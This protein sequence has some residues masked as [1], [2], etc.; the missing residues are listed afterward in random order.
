[1]LAVRHE[2]TSAALVRHEIAAD[3][4]RCAIGQT[5]IDEVVLVASELV[6]NAIR[7]TDASQAPLQISWDVDGDGVMVRV[8]DPSDTLPTPLRA[9]PRACSGRGLAI[10]EAMS[11]RWG[12]DPAA[13]GK[14]VWAHV[15]VP[16]AELSQAGC[17]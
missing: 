17:A 11:D 7:H 16:P 6:G 4:A 10:V 13:G 9:G 2:P 3:L 1:M 5:S 15:P 14:R 8:A 12:V